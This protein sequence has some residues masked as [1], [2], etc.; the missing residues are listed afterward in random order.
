M[1]NLRLERYYSQDLMPWG[2]MS[3]I[4][5]LSSPAHI[6]WIKRRACVISKQYG[7]DAHHVQFRSHGLNDYTAIPLRHDLHMRG[8]Q[9]GF[10]KLEDEHGVSMKDALIATLVERVAFLEIALGLR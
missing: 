10:D 7:A 8:H 9:A 4:P 6:D 1:S 3:K 2:S 5:V